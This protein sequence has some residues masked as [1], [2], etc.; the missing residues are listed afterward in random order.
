MKRP[1]RR[2]FAG[3]ALLLRLYV[4]ALIGILALSLTALIAQPVSAAELESGGEGIS[5]TVKYHGK[6]TRTTAFRETVA[7]LLDRM[8]LE[9][10]GEDVV[11]HGMDEPVREGMQ[12]QVD[13]VITVTE[14]Y[15]AAIAHPVTR[16]NAPSVP[17]GVEAVLAE[18]MD[19][20][21]LCTARVTYINGVEAQRQILSQTVTRAAVPEVIG[22]GTA[23]EAPAVDPGGMPEI[24]D[25][26][27]TLPTGEVLTYTD[28]ATVRATA[29]THTDAGCDF[30][31]STGT[32]VRWGTVAVDPRFIPYGTRMFIVAS[33][34]SY[35]YGLAM[36]ED[37]GGDIKGDR[38]DL[39]MPTYEQCMEF[40][41][42]T[43]TVYYLG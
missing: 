37:C 2:V 20:E 10:A 19:G 33:N 22:I 25:G 32:T 26:Y 17:E 28:T 3:K 30:I 29:Y 9:V 40:G 8:G 21:L 18:G 15:T 1:G 13:R 4:L 27:I 7:Q 38:M 34:G 11:S 6:T 16:C 23:P 24:G 14:T 12:L 43:C 41:R 36:A 39:Y 31:T 5:V 35:I 42:R